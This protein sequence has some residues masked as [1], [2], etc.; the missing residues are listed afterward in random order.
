MSLDW[1]VVV[2]ISIHT[3]TRVV[4]EDIGKEIGIDRNFN[5]HH[6]ESGDGSKKYKKLKLD[7]FNPHH[8]ESGDTCKPVILRHRHD[9]NPHHYESGDEIPTM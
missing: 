6:Y 1:G 3:T 8:Y 4:T 5:P 2:E 7:D 9:F